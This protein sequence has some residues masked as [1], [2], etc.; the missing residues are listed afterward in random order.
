MNNLLFTTY[1]STMQSINMAFALAA[2]LAWN[3]VIKSF[4]TRIV[5]KG[6][7]T[8]GHYVLFALLITLLA[9]IIFHVSKNYLNA[10]IDK[11]NVS[12]IAGM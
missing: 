5:P 9:A 7:S 3:D 4:I 11:K 8:L 12:Y 1:N 10:N 2:A 6:K